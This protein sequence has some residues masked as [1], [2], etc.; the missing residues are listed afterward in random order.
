M[1][2]QEIIE[3]IETLLDSNAVS[4]FSAIQRYDLVRSV[5]A[6]VF[7][8]DYET[9]ELITEAMGPYYEDYC[10][11]DDDYDDEDVELGPDSDVEQIVSV[12]TGT[13]DVTF[14]YV[15]KTA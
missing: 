4:G 9:E 7:C 2:S 14:S 13:R 15:Q 11:V 12:S 1:T 10:C 5:A 3:K 6:A 8:N